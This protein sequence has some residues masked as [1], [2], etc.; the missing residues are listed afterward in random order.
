MSNT[1]LSSDICHQPDLRGLHG[2]FIEPLSISSTTSLFPILGGS[3][4]SVNN[5]ILIPAPVY[6]SGEDR[7]SAAGAQDIDWSSKMNKAIWRGV[8]T[9]GH[10][11][12][13]NWRG[14]H[15]HRF[16]AMSNA[17]ILSMIE[18]GIEPAPNFVFP[19]E[20][21]EL[22]AQKDNLLGWWTNQWSDCA[23]TDLMCDQGAGNIQNTI[24]CPYVDDHFSIRSSIPMEVQFQS[25]Y[26]PDID[27]N[28]FSGRYLAFLRSTS[29]PVKATLWKEW[30]DARLFAWK[31]YVPMDNRYGDWFGI[32][33]YF[34]GYGGS[35]PGHDAVAQKIATEGRD[36]ALKVM[37]KED[38]QVYVLRLLLEYARVLDDKRE[39][40]GWVGDLVGQE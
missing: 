17:T 3:K 2:I 8:A 21:Y 25:K 9:G 29:L 30:H 37:R 27:G 16:V 24:S 23:F 14:F 6:W 11:R 38:M 20:H 13:S 35:S 40:L 32:M 31:H 26:L 1:T 36:W 18:N 19:S 15:R 34:L 39:L 12:E 28:S 5:D 22:K 4:L 33:E 7:F 10:N